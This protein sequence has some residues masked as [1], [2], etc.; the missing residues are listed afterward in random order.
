[1]N[2]TPAE[3]K[4]QANRRKWLNCFLRMSKQHIF[5]Q[6]QHLISDWQKIEEMLKKESDHRPSNDTGCKDHSDNETIY[7]CSTD[8][9]MYKHM[10]MYRCAITKIYNL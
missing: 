10:C 4:T 9:K 5:K 3:D 2:L 8:K 6:V 1:M 7:Y